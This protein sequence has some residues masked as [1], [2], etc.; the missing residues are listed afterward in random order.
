MT[1]GQYSPGTI[2]LF[3]GSSA[4][5]KAKRVIAET[6]PEGAKADPNAT[7][8]T[9]ATMNLVDWDQD[10]DLDM[11]IGSTA[12]TVAVNLN[13]GTPKA[14]KFGRRRPVL[15]IDEKPLR[16]SQTSDPLPVDWDGDGTLD[17]LVGDEAGDVNF[18]RGTKDRK[19]ERGISLFSG[20][21]LP[22]KPSYAAVK[23]SLGDHPTI[24]GYRLRLD[25]ADWNGDG[26]L[27]LLVGNCEAEEDAPDLHGFVYLL[28]RK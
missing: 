3:E 24:P 4:G 10:G 22:A 23:K 16:V 7:D 6:S 13:E 2:N 18:F 9:M 26:K 14:A 28:L 20:A 8:Q 11:V 27:D 19:F 1:S 21:E 12:R 5:F 25:A 17:L 15:G